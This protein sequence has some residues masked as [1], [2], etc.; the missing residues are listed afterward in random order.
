VSG[1]RPNEDVAMTDPRT[2]A[3]KRALDEWTKF[4]PDYYDLGEFIVAIE[5]EAAEQE[6]R[7]IARLGA[8]TTTAERQA[9][10]LRKYNPQIVAVIEAEATAAGIDGADLKEARDR[11]ATF[12]GDEATVRAHAVAQLDALLGSQPASEETTPA[13]SP[14]EK[15]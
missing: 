2:E 13:F 3:G 10:A 1:L 11:I 12:H 14:P 6:H 7:R 4:D 15:P 8:E 9:A 5:A